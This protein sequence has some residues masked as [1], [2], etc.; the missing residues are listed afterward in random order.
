MNSLARGI[1]QFQ[2]FIQFEAIGVSAGN[3][4]TRSTEALF[5]ELRVN[6][7]A[8]ILFFRFVFFPFPFLFFSFSLSVYL[9]LRRV[10]GVL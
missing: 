10:D 1:H 8:F 6:V 9:Y 7:F 5:S 3:H 2:V 4:L